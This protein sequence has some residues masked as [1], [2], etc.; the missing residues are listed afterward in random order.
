MVQA[1]YGLDAS[2]CSPL[3]PKGGI[4]SEEQSISGGTWFGVGGSLWD[5]A[6]AL[7][8]CFSE[9]D[10]GKCEG[11]N[12]VGGLYAIAD[13]MRDIAIEISNLRKEIGRGK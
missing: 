8:S 10:H 2:L 11:R 4:V 6:N 5:V 13:A 9:Y 3:F 12:V 7:N 1:N